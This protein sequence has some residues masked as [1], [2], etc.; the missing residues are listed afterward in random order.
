[1]A[2]ADLEKKRKKS[3]EWMRLRRKSIRES[4]PPKPQ[5]LQGSVTVIDAIPELELDKPN[6]DAKRRSQKDIILDDVVVIRSH[7]TDLTA[8]RDNLRPRTFT[9]DDPIY[10]K[11][12]EEEEHERLVKVRTTYD[13]AIAEDEQRIE[14]KKQELTK[15]KKYVKDQ[16]MRMNDYRRRVLP[17]NLGDI[18]Q[19]RVDAEANLAMH[20]NKLNDSPSHVDRVYAERG[21]RLA[22]AKL[23]TLTE[24]ERNLRRTIPEMEADI[25]NIE[26]DW[27]AQRRAMKE[28]DKQRK[29][30]EKQ[31]ES[32]P[33]ETG[34]ADDTPLYVKF[35]EPWGGYN[36]NSCQMISALSEEVAA[37]LADNGIVEIVNAPHQGVSAETT[38]ARQTAMANYRI[39]PP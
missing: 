4:T 35:L 15:L 7:L 28:L 17:K 26:G 2:Y 8:R 12:L 25:A 36:E 27:D 13:A 9:H 32:M 31:A 23:R 34:R 10:L 21:K 22:E 38:L 14:N 37:D 20:T 16:K 6:D 33:K 19:E 1:M 29:Q 5:K 24:K 11:A 30:Y 3:R 39:L 18:E